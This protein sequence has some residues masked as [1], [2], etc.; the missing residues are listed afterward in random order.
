MTLA[1]KTVTHVAVQ[2]RTHKLYFDLQASVEGI[3][4]EE[5]EEAL[6]TA[7]DKCPYCIK[8]AT[9][10]LLQIWMLALLP[11]QLM[12]LRLLLLQCRFLYTELTPGNGVHDHRHERRRLKGQVRQADGSNQ[13]ASFT[14]K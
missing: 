9:S 2:I 11:K 14:R 10:L 4:A 7:L 12:M 8:V 1:V 6:K 3:A 5:S 13:R